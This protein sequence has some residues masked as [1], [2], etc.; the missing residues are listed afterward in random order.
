MTAKDYDQFRSFFRHAMVEKPLANIRA[1][2]AE[3]ESLKSMDDRQIQGLIDDLALMQHYKTKV[4]SG[5]EEF[6]KIMDGFY[7]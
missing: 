2:L 6:E 4:H 5:N 7:K 3:L 1:K